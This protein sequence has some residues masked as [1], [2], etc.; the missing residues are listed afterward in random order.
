MVKYFNKFRVRLRNGSLIS[1]PDGTMST[2]NR[3]AAD[4]LSMYLRELE[5]DSKVEV[6][7]SSVKLDD[8]VMAPAVRE[9]A[10]QA[11]IFSGKGLAHNAG[12]E[13]NRS[14]KDYLFNPA[15]IRAKARI[16]RL[17][18]QNGNRF[19]RVI[20]KPVIIHEL[21]QSVAMAMSVLYSKGGTVL[22]KPKKRGG[23]DD[24]DAKHEMYQIRGD[25]QF[26]RNTKQ[27]E[28]A[29]S[30]YKSHGFVEAC[31]QVRDTF[32]LSNRVATRIVTYAANA[33]A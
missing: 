24:W 21:K 7:S 10:R 20:D 25:L 1:F 5:V 2:F 12:E 33:L 26:T 19:E 17:I 8:P 6:F 18:S 28:F 22:P 14:K 30:V 3:A 29:L 27:D 23:S 9:A 11:K 4:E 16:Q 32:K 13:R 31:R 15:Y